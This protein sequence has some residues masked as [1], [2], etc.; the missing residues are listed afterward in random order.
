MNKN[1]GSA[2]KWLRIVFG[3]LILSQVFVGLQTL[4]GIVGLVL[5]ATALI[6]FCPIYFLLGMK[7]TSK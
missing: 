6:N 7:S 3:G 4:W 2:D 1:I 5:I